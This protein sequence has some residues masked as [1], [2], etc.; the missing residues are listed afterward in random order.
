LIV[1]AVDTPLTLLAE[2]EHTLLGLGRQVALPADAVL[3]T[4]MIRDG[5]PHYAFSL[6]VPDEEVVDEVRRYFPDWLSALSIDHCSASA[7][8]TAG[9]QLASSEALARSGG[10]C[11]RFPGWDRVVGTP[12]VAEILATS[13]IERLEV[14]GGQPAGPADVVHSRDFVRPLWRG[15]RLVLPVLPSGPGAVAPF[16][17]PNPTPCCSDHTTPAT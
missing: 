12:T 9:L 16:E 1:L 4:H 3:C 13:A 11:V 14:L 8:S 2:T 6:T 7:G 5:E 15:G 17:L 10:R